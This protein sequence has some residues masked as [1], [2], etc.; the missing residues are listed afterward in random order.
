MY[1]KIYISFNTQNYFSVIY[2]YIY[3]FYFFHLDKVTCFRRRF[4]LKRSGF[5]CLPS[6]ATIAIITI[7]IIIIVT[8]TIPFLQGHIPIQFVRAIRYLLMFAV[9]LIPE[10]RQ[11]NK[12]VIDQHPLNEEHKPAELE[13]RPVGPALAE[14]PIAGRNDVVDEEVCDPN[15]CAADALEDGADD[16]GGVVRHEHGGHVVHQ[17]GAGIE[18]V[19]E[20]DL[21]VVLDHDGGVLDIFTIGRWNVCD[22]KEENKGAY[23]PPEPFKSN[24]KCRI[25]LKMKSN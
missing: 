23:A 12:P 9:L 4:T 20:N 5:T 7:V 3:Y 17:N 8:V 14:P 21:G 11:P 22:Q 10:A 1:T 13:V 25:E 19:G 18:K 6:D 15:A 24:N 2:I 16:S